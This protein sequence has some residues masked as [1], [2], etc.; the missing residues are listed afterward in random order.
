MPQ[1][2]T[3]QI[4][5][6]GQYSLAREFHFVCLL[7]TASSFLMVLERLKA[8]KVASW[9]LVWELDFILILFYKALLVIG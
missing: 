3:E 2:L 5:T 8:S 6:V 1:T 4:N 9:M 7:S